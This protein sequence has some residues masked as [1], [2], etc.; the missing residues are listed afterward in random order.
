MVPALWCAYNQLKIKVRALPTCKKPVGDGAKRTRGFKSSNWLRDEEKL[1]KERLDT[2]PGK[3][4]FED[5]LIQYLAML[6]AVENYRQATHP[7]Q[8][9][10]NLTH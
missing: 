8:L 2:L 1:D 6:R 9:G 7:G 3:G 10:L 5:W 4:L